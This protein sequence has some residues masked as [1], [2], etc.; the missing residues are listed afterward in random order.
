M[1][2]FRIIPIGLDKW[3]VEEK[4]PG[5]PAYEVIQ[6]DLEAE[7]AAEEFIDKKIS[8]REKIAYRK[9][10]YPPREYPTKPTHLT[11]VSD[12]DKPSS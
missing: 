4:K 8:T 5:S 12:Q 3:A 11:L 6:S 7:G 2:Q 10:K 1:S 9:K